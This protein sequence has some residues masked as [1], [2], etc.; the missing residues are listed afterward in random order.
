[1]NN[2][3]G[4]KLKIFWWITALFLISLPILNILNIL[5]LNNFIHRR[6]VY[7]NDL[8]AIIMILILFTSINWNV[9]IRKYFTTIIV[10]FTLILTVLLSSLVSNT[11]IM[12]LFWPGFTNEV[13]PLLLG[14]IFV[15][16]KLEAEVIV[17]KNIYYTFCLVLVV[18]SILSFFNKDNPNHSI[19]I[20]LLT[21][22]VVYILHAKGLFFSNVYPKLLITFVT[23][24]HLI[25]SPLTVILNL[26]ILLLLFFKDKDFPSSYI[27][28]GKILLLLLTL[29]IG[30]G[31]NLSPISDQNRIKIY[32]ALKEN[33]SQNTNKIGLGYGL[34]NIGESGVVD[35]GINQELLNNRPI[36]SS[37][38]IGLDV[39]EI[40]KVSNWMVQTIVNNGIFYFIAFIYSFI[41][42]YFYNKRKD[43]IVFL[44]I[45]IFTLSF[46]YDPLGN[47]NAFYLFAIS[48]FLI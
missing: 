28:F 20:F 26:V 22:I 8:L 33:L 10:L 13:L 11:S 27:N 21:N 5:N 1:M 30:L 37:F 43:H 40:A 44:T 12:Y 3:R 32:V 41:L 4:N 39:R 16:S 14:L 34:G 29:F 7:L 46:F 25:V 45:V 47:S 15:V 35:Y 17:P 23:I 9:I 42:I 24:L 36:F 48:L 19:L 31:F 2:L 6:I 38:D 18:E